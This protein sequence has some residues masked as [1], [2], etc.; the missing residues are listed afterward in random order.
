[1]KLND[2][3]NSIVISFVLENLTILKCICV[4]RRSTLDMLEFTNYFR[5]E[6]QI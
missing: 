1:M 3:G 4:V 5:L 6:I 2:I